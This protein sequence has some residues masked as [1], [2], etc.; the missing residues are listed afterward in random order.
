MGRASLWR[1]SVGK[2]IVIRCSAEVGN[3]AVVGILTSLSFRVAL[4]VVLD[5]KNR[6]RRGNVPSCHKKNQKTVGWLL[7]ANSTFP[8]GGK[9]RRGEE[10]NVGSGRTCSRLI[11]HSIARACVYTWTIRVFTHAW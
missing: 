4:V 2:F 10:G 9:V 5:C 3:D 11:V 6:K 7:A 1:L 8:P